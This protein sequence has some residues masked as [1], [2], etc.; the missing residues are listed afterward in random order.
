MIVLPDFLATSI[1]YLQSY[2]RPE[3]GFHMN[4][5][6]TYHILHQGRVE[7]TLVTPGSPPHV[8]VKIMGENIAAGEMR[9]LIVGTGIWKSSRLLTEDLESAKSQ[10]EQDR[11]FSLIT[12]VVVPGFDWR[13][14]EWMRMDDLDGLFKDIDG[15]MMIVESMRKR[16][17]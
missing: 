12:E 14:H 15:G 3:S 11:C 7:Y 8:E 2:H 16:K 6:V 5:S 10:E 4:K 13:D 17:M 1:Y 9:Q